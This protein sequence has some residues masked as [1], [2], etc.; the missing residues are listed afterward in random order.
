MSERQDAIDI[1]NGMI[2]D[3]CVAVEVLRDY[4]HGDYPKR[5]D[6][7]RQGIYRLCLQSIIL[8]L[9]KFTEFCREY[10]KLIH[11]CCPE[12][13]LQKNKMKEAL[14]RK[15]V[16]DI[17]S[18]YIAHN[19]CDKTKSPLST[20]EIDTLLIGVIGSDYAQDFLDWLHPQIAS[21]EDVPESFTGYISLVRDKFACFG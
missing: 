13:T 17:R 11:E 8:N 15:K 4:E 18:K 16:N 1:L 12:L 10:G 14:E 5:D 7:F 6:L 2:L 20:Q 21:D 9:A 3:I 19:R